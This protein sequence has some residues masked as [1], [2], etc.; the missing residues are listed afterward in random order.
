MQ[1]LVARGA[2]ALWVGGDNTMMSTLG[3]AIA[4]ART[5]RI[6]VFT[7]MPGA[8][9]R[10]TL[11]DIGLDFHELGRTGGLLAGRVLQG[12][13]PATLPIRDVQDE[14]PRRVVVNTLALAGCAS[15]ASFPTP[16]GPTP[17]CSWTPRACTSAPRR[18]AGRWRGRGASI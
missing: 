6:P 4:T 8:A 12:L 10:G 16:C 14:V 9:D 15:L 7:I 2:Q 3:S 13:D 11:F 17:P 5:A 18:L 1:S